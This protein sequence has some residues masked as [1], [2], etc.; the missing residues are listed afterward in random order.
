MIKINSL[1]Q[2]WVGK[3]LPREHIFIKSADK[4][5]TLSGLTRVYFRKW[6]VHPLKRKIAKYYLMVLR[7]FFGLKVVGITGS[8][9]KTTTKDMLASILKEAT[10][11]RIGSGMTAKKAPQRFPNGIL[12]GESVVF[13]FANI[14]PVYNI[15]TTILKCRPRTRYLVLEMGVEYPGEMD[16]YLW[17]ATP[18][19]GV[20]TNINPT[21]TEF[22]KNVDGVFTEKSKLVKALPKTAMAVLNKN[23]THL[24]KLAGKLKAKIVW[25]DGTDEK[26]VLLQNSD[27]LASVKTVARKLGVSEDK[28]KKGLA[29]FVPQDH[30]MKLIHHPS[31]AV[32][33][34][35]S[36]NN[37]PKAA[38][39]SIR[40][41][42]KLAGK[43]Q[44]SLIFGDMLELGSLEASE[45][46]KIGDLITQIDFDQVILVGKAVK[47]IKVPGAGYFSTWQ[48]ARPAFEKLLVGGNYLLVKGSRSVGLENLF[49][50]VV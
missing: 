22:F 7:R 25:F 1:I 49:H 4:P 50:G 28:I 30:R 20:I 42:V 46:R 15:P 32:I 40:E 6:V 37:N 11:S 24:Q 34:D 3:G 29:N 47:N 17:L 12:G 41:F 5:K 27:N 36:Y 2:M 44:K 18:D 23:D 19:I 48:E 26:K 21:H 10:G 33:V 38:D 45:H 31:G 14:D 9:G 43:N 13:S 39:F 8:C 35:D 16:Y